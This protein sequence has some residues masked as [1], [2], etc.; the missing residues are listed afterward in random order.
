M[1]SSRERVK[2]ALNH[3]EPDRIPLDLGGS[4]VTGMHVSTV[5]LLRQALGLDPPATPVKVIDPYQML[6]EIKLDLIAA[7]GV[8]VV[9]LRSPKTSFGFKNEGWRPWTFNGTPV[10]V[11][12]G[13]NT[14]PEADGSLLMYPQGDKSAPPS[15]KMPAGGWYFDALIR[16]EPIDDERAPGAPLCR[17]GIPNQVERIFQ[18]TKNA[19][20]AVEQKKQSS[21][22]SNRIGR[23]CCGIAQNRLNQKGSVVADVQGNLVD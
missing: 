11:P 7:L 23:R 8:D 18:F 2:L 10:L 22:G 21:N 1:I 3:Q 5:Y 12:A 14:V 6:G 9:P 19:R 16:Q 20:G 15:G 4:S 17:Y 13:F